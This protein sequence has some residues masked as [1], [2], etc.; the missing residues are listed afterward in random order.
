MELYAGIDVLVRA[1]DLPL[2]IKGFL[3]EDNG[4][5]YIYINQNISFEQQ[6]KAVRHEY[7]HLI[8]DDL[9]SKEN[10]INIERRNQ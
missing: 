3:K 10:T 4:F 5:F 9:Y 8:K 6:I 7:N 1:I 2:H